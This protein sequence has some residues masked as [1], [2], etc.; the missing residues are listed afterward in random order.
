MRKTLSK[1]T[2]NGSSFMVWALSDLNDTELAVFLFDEA[3]NSH[4]KAMEGSIFALL[5]APMLTASEKNKF[6]FKVSKPEE[7]VALGRAVD[8]GICKGTT[9]GEARCR[10]AINTA[11]VNPHELKASCSLTLMT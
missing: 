8:F 11:Q 10:I 9:S 2:T 6:A 5:N 7:I 1:A 4:W 3:Y